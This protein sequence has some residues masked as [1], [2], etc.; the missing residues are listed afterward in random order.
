MTLER[1]LDEE[2][3]AATAAM[4]DQSDGETSTDGGGGSENKVHPPLLTLVVEGLLALSAQWASVG[5]GED[6]AF[7]D[8]SGPRSPGAPKFPYHLA[9]MLMTHV[10]KNA[11]YVGNHPDPLANYVRAGASI[12]IPGWQA[13]LMRLNEKVFR[14]GTI[15]S[16]PG[17]TPQ[18]GEVVQETLTDI[19]ILCLI[20]NDLWEQNR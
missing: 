9:Q 1:T 16:T 8:V 20:T 4:G 15:L 6:G 5:Q 3:E 12:G 11:A 17:A 10:N 7:V 19:A 13:S 2:I 14:L 18:D